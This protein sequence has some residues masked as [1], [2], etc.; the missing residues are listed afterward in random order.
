[1]ALQIFGKHRR[2]PIVPLPFQ[3]G[4]QFSGGSPELPRRQQFFQGIHN[5]SQLQLL[6]WHGPA[7][8]A[9]G[10]F[11]FFLHVLNVPPGGIEG[12]GA[13]LAFV[14]HQDEGSIR[15]TSQPIGARQPVEWII[16][17]HFA[18]MVDDQQADA[19]AVSQC[20][21]DAGILVVAA[22][23]HPT[24]I[25][26]SHLL[27]RIQH[28]QPDMRIFCKLRFDLPFQAPAY[29]RC[30]VAEVQ[31]L[32]RGIRQPQSPAVQPLWPVLQ[33]QVE[34]LAFPRCAPQK[35]LSAAHSEAQLQR[36]P[37]LAHLG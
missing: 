15:R 23:G 20:F 36:H 10:K 16:V 19:I 6:L 18:Q 9:V 26:T 30:T 2:T 31:P 14:A 13:I 17:R 33:R 28:Y 12:G 7:P 5:Q 25:D 4:C 27:Q 37:A 35:G 32:R 11:Q 24:A 29:G 34:H 22:V 21:Q 8:P 1:M 3:L